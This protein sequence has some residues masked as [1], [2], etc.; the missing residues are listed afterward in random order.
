MVAMASEIFKLQV[1]NVPG[2]LFETRC[3]SCNPLERSLKGVE[4][5]E[6]GGWHPARPFPSARMEMFGGAHEHAVPDAVVRHPAGK[7]CLF[8]SHLTFVPH[9]R[10]K[11]KLN[12]RSNLMPRGRKIDRPFDCT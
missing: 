12:I 1:S 10:S 9:I 3:L 8:N 2:S 7:C 6:R 5:G 11:A 4:S